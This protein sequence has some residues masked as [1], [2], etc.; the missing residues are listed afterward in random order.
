M[1]Q[2]VLIGVSGFEKQN[3]CVGFGGTIVQGVVGKHNAVDENHALVIFRL[4]GNPVIDEHR[5][6]NRRGIHKELLLLRH[7]SHGQLACLNAERK[8][9]DRFWSAP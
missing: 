5:M 9:A 3:Q 1:R 8:K 4:K 2:I 6:G 7:Q